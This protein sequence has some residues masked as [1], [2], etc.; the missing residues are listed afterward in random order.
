MGEAKR[1]K[2]LD[3]TWGR[4]RQQ[5]QEKPR[6]EDVAPKLVEKIIANPE[7]H[8]KTFDSESASRIQDRSIAL[9]MD[10]NFMLASMLQD[11]QSNLKVVMFDNHVS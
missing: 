4:K 3:P 6:S 2:N 1:R 7:W 10:K 11:H 9:G 8:S 5:L